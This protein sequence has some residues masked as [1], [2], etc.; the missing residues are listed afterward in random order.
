MNC[1][2]FFFFYTDCESNPPYAIKV[3]DI[4][5]NQ[6]DFRL[7][8]DIAAVQWPNG[9]RIPADSPKC[10]FDGQG[11]MTPSPALTLTSPDDNSKIGR[12]NLQ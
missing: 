11:C 7:N 5:F 12:L 6:E 2:L 3:G 10:G 8:I 4:T 9:K 1:S